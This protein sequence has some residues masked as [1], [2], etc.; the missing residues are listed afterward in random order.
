MFDDHGFSEIVS[1]DGP[2]HTVVHNR[3]PAFFIKAK[4]A[5]IV[6]PVEAQIDTLMGKIAPAMISPPFFRRT[7]QHARTKKPAVKTVSVQ[8]VFFDKHFRKT[9]FFQGYGFEQV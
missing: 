9:S 3:D 6:I 8:T 5:P 7:K 2:N 4:R 1:E